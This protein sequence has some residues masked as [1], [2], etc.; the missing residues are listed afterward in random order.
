[1]KQEKIKKEGKVLTTQG[2][3]VLI[4]KTLEEND[5]FI[6]RR[7]WKDEKGKFPNY[8]MKALVNGDDKQEHYIDITP[9]MFS[10]LK[11][12]DETDDITAYKWRVYKFVSQK[13]EKEGYSCKVVRDRSLKTFNDFTDEQKKEIERKKELMN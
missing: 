7:I 13:Y 3:E 11:E 12:R 6:P 10:V 2:R 8:K 9:T 4:K 5:V 1:M